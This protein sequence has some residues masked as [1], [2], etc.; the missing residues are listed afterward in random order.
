MSLR[1]ETDD[2]GD[3]IARLGELPPRDIDPWRA[4]KIRRRS[5]E[6]LKRAAALNSRPWLATTARIYNRVLEPAFV[7]GVSAVYLA[8]AISAVSSI[9][10]Y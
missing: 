6:A 1:D 4:E 9:L 5:H 8:W 3:T 7:C 2:K 10:G